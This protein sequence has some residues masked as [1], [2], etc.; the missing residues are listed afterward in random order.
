[1]VASWPEE[2]LKLIWAYFSLIFPFVLKEFRVILA[3][4]RVLPFPEWV[5]PAAVVFSSVMMVDLCVTIA[6]RALISIG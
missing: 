3:I 4:I 2:D 5:H 1:M 6:D